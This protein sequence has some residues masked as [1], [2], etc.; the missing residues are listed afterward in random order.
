V[1]R[2]IGDRPKKDSIS[3]AMSPGTRNHRRPVARTGNELPRL[4]RRQLQGVHPSRSYWRGLTCDGAHVD[5]IR[6]IHDFW[7][8]SRTSRPTASGDAPLMVWFLT[9]YRCGARPAQRCGFRGDEPTQMKALYRAQ[10]RIPKPPAPD[11][12]DQRD[13]NLSFPL[14]GDYSLLIEVDDEPL[15]ATNLTVSQ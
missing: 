5:P 11:Q 12:S 3:V 13:P 2:A 6:E 8:S 1:I 4:G 15:L 9:A 10:L 7:G 14:R